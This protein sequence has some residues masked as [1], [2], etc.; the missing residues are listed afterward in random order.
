MIY[1]I[2]M[3]KLEGNSSWLERLDYECLQELCSESLQVDAYEDVD[4]FC[5][6]LESGRSY[7]AVLLGQNSSKGKAI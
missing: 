1:E 2:A 5:E 6:A 3:L 7:Q 4:S